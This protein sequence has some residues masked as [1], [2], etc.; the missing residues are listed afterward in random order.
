MSKKHKLP[1]T[2]GL[3]LKNRTPSSKPF[4]PTDDS[5]RD[6][7]L[8][9]LKKHERRFGELQGIIDGYAAALSGNDFI[10]VNPRL[11]RGTP[12]V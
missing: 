12:K 7:G 8:S 1:P 5:G 10:K 9:F 11:C 6:A 3:E 4:D 2:L